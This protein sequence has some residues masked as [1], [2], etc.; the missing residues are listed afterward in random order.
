MPCRKSSEMRKTALFLTAGSDTISYRNRLRYSLKLIQRRR[1][2]AYLPIK[3][4]WRGRTGRSGTQRKT[5]GK[6]RNLKYRDTGNTI[7]LTLMMQGTTTLCLTRQ[8]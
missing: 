6:G 4:N 8:N 5:S 1:H 7:H 2:G 3:E